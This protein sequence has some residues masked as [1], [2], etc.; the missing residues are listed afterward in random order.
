M[1]QELGMH[2]TWASSGGAGV[3]EWDGGV[4]LACLSPGLSESSWTRLV[5]D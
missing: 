2:S 4:Q 1:P 5:D 3:T